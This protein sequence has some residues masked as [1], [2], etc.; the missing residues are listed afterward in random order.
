V[1]GT[2]PTGYSTPLTPG[3]AATP[4]SGT[5][6]SGGAANLSVGSLDYS[7]HDDAAASGRAAAGAGR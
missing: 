3:T 5:R 7:D 4:S 2:V 1:A 6:T